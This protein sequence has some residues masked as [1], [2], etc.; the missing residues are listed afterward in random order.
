MRGVRPGEGLALKYSSPSRRRL[1][2][3]LRAARETPKVLTT[4]FFFLGV[5]RSTAWSALILRSF[6]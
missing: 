2:H 5:A 6:E 1:S 3:L 4:S